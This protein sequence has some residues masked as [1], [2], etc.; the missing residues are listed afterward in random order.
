MEKEN[1]NIA[2]ALPL[3]A[4]ETPNKVAVCAPKKR[5]SGQFHYESLS[6]K[7][8]NSR[9]LFYAHAFKDRGLK[10]GDKVLMF[11]KPSVDFSALTFSLFRLGLVPIFIDPGMG[12]K[13]LLRAVEH[14]KPDALV[15]EPIVHLIALIYPRAFKSIKISYTMG[16]FAP[17]KLES[18]ASLRLAWKRQKESKLTEI[19]YH[20]EKETMAAILFTSGGTGI[21]KAVHYNHGIFNAQVSRLQELFQLGPDDID[22]P[23]FPLFSLFTITMGMKSAIPAM[24]PSK[25]A[26][27][28]PKYLVQN[29]RDHGATFVAGS[30]AIWQNMVEYCLAEEITLP[31]VKYL[32]MFGAPVPN[33]LHRDFQ[34]V[35]T[36]GDTFTPYGATECLP[37]ANISGSQVLTLHDKLNQ[38]QR[39]R[40]VSTCVGYPV[41]HTEV[42]IAP[43]SERPIASA[44][45]VSWQNTGEMG[46]VCVYSETVTPEYIGMKKKTD[47]AKIKDP[48]GGLWHRM[49]DLGHLDQEGR[50]WFCGRLTHRLHIN[51]KTL[52]CIPQESIYNDIPTI[53]RSAFVGPIIEG[54]THPTLIIQP[55]GNLSSRERH[56]LTD[57]ILALD[58]RNANLLKQVIFI[59]KMP[60]DVRHNIKID[61][62]KLKQEVEQ[63]ILS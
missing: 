41:A 30:P 53:K 59:K 49:G 51:G 33:K 57:Y 22:L 11:V 20:C 56:E 18:I 37:V 46:E 62:I 9:S 3:W 61:R 13:N 24:N 32:V 17:G 29:I 2:R 16:S 19:M 26:L 8:L 28:N 7:I 40:G 10:A 39:D 45:Q 47:L 43:I 35:L 31:T 63:G 50:L 23:G 34:K 21:P 1:Y 6:F 58:K 14:I 15:A 36:H 38:E 5:Q 55:N 27:A 44:D 48:R 54:I 4:Q 12:R 52:P 42:R 60:L 25:P